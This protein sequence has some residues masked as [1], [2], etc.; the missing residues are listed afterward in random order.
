MSTIRHTNSTGPTPTTTQPTQLMI[1]FSAIPPT[2][3]HHHRRL[4]PAYNDIIIFG[5]LDVTL[6][7]YISTRSRSE[8]KNRQ[9]ILAQPFIIIKSD[10]A[11]RHSTDVL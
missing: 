9:A 10:P 3:H 1:I 11:D 8:L 4:L 5:G 7:T 2:Q 6:G